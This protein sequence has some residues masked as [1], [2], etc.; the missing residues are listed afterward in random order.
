MA[1]IMYVPRISVRLLESDVIL[2]SEDVHPVYVTVPLLLDCGH[3][4]NTSTSAEI[5][6]GP[7]SFSDQ[8][9]DTCVDGLEEPPDVCPFIPDGSC[10][11]L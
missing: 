5:N 7:P 4:S 11:L 1:S 9:S 2:Q 3:Q 6:R 8:S 10:S